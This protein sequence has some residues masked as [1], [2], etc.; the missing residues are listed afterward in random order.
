MN[1]REQL[2]GWML[3]V[4]L[5]A[6][7]TH[8]AAAQTSPATQNP[9][10]A[11]S[12]PSAPVAAGGTIKGT[13]KAGNV[14]LPGVSVTATNT[15]TGKKFTTTTD[16]TGAYEMTIPQNGR[17]VVRAELA[18]FALATKEALLNATNH[19]QQSDFAMVLASRAEQ[20]EQASTRQYAAA[21][22]AQSLALMGAASDLLQAGSGSANSGA[23]LP[24]IAGNTDFSGDS[25][26]VTGQAGTTSPFA[27]MG[28]LRE[29]FENQQQLQQLSQTPGQ[30]GGGGGFFG[31][32][33]GGF[34]GPGG[35]GGGGRGGG[36]GNFRN[37]KPSQPHGA[38]FW[39]G[40]PSTFNAQPFAVR[41]QAEPNLGYDTNHYGL[42]IAGEPF[43]PKITKPST[44]DFVFLT[45]A[46]QHSTSP[47]N[48][49]GTVPTNPERTG[50]FSDLVG[51]NGAVIPI[52]NPA[53]GQQFPN[54]TINTPLSPQALAV[55]NYIPAPNLPGTTQNYRLLTTSGTN[56]DNIG[57]RWNHSFGA[58]T[59]N[60]PAIAR[61]FIN[62]GTGL[63]QSINAN[64]NY[65]HSASDDVNL[66]YQLGGKQETH[67]YSLAAG[68]SIGKGKLTNNFT[69]TWNRNNSQL[70]NFFTNVE[71]VSTQVGI[72]GPDD[73]P[74]N[75]DPLNYG[76]PNFV[77]NQF[78]GLNQQQANYRL[79]QT[80]ALSESSSWR[81]G[82][83]NV[84]FGGDFHRVQLNLLGGTNSTGSFYF[85]GFATQEPGSGTNNQVATSGSSFADFL[86]GI[87]QE[88]TIQ[89][90]DEKAYMRQNTWD[91]FAQDDWRAL[92][93]LT[94]LA[95]LRYEYFSPYAE[96]ND[97]LATLDYNSG[98]TDVSAVYPN[99]I[100]S[101]SGVKYPRT[102]IYP[103]RNNF[104]P[105]LG[106]AWRPFKDTVVRAGYGINFT[107]G[108]YGNF[109]QNLAYQPPFANVQNNQ[110]TVT[111]DGFTGIC[112]TA[113]SL[114][115]CFTGQLP[116]NYSV[117]PHYRLP[118]VQVWNLDIQRTL[119]LAIVLNV[120][121]NGAKGTRLDVLSAP[122]NYPNLTPSQ[123]SGVY[124]NFEDAVAFSN[125]NA[126]V[127]RANKRLQNGVSL[128]M[129]YTYSHSI[130]DASSVGAGSGVV[131]QDWQNILAEESNSSFDIRNQV[132]GSFL[133]ELPFGPDKHYLSN[134]NWASHAFGDWS[135]SGSY[136]LADGTPLTPAISASVANVARG[137]AGSVRP[138]RVPGTSITAGGGHI[139]NW[140]NTAAFSSSFAP[141]QYYGS[142][143][144]Y[145]IP[146]PGTTVVN[147]SLSKTFQ[148]KDTK[149]FEVRMT[150]DNAFNIVQYAGVNTQFD[151]TAVGEVTSARQMR[152]I[153]FLARYR[154]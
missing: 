83:H 49:Y 26:A 146:G 132:R 21:S 80:F 6:A 24:T 14:P 63:N 137:S 126:L 88:S 148:L 127:V 40:G 36:R 107:V 117:N 109:I 53:T 152:T 39:N 111:S 30:G 138:D 92:P 31:G 144:R 42:T 143:S 98:F 116:A 81:H 72:L 44:K 51:T 124:F 4:S 70:R 11:E 56:T 97:R 61:Q 17:Y 60:I 125:F 57:V 101:I 38:I 149:S 103:E 32:P 153:T 135:L 16:V 74:L 34:G 87:P 119:P 96:T 35:G 46:G 122:G 25:V 95:G 73:T 130:D 55:L 12:L 121:Y 75:P 64:F 52:Y 91:L 9:P 147:V 140:F 145:S 123:P 102:L 27:G 76:L 90:P 93:N 22:G 129:T 94:I 50:N 13:I 58:S 20:Q 120:G 136:T 10:V 69:F 114:A 33:G 28:D 151:S 48:E 86:L 112:G 104:A 19:Q 118:Y 115:N 37:F 85:T 54:N 62:T 142:A 3:A 5:S 77:F 68:Y 131:A 8:V 18:A 108:Q 43:I 78:T 67:S 29:G 154:F 110:A 65:S 47:V 1:F 150:A 71:D 134:G 59:G 128:Q 41:G 100:G 139:N 45:L 113:G 7:I 106:I 141:G 89:S 23:A 105:R 2:A 84:R 66:F 133:Y 82:K 15:L 99:Q 79:T